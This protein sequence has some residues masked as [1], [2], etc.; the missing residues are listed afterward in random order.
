VPDENA[1]VRRWKAVRDGVVVAATAVRVDD[2]TGHLSYD[3]PAGE[4]P[5]VVVLVEGALGA[6][7]QVVDLRA[8]SRA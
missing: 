1:A 4:R 5:H 8:E 7:H 3:G 2:G 6:D